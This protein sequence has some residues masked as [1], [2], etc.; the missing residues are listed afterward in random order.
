MIADSVLLRRILRLC[1]DLVEK[2][3]LGMSKTDTGWGRAAA[4]GMSSFYALDSSELLNS[5]MK[6]S[7]NTSRLYQ[8]AEKGGR[9][10]SLKHLCPSLYLYLFL[11]T[12]FSEV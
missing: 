3:H 12:F 9:T 1:L 6:P 2:Y 5:S 4:E 10:L 11:I 8:A 7:G